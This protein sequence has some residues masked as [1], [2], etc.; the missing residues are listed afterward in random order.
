MHTIS[1]NDINGHKGPLNVGAVPEGYDAFLVAQLLQKHADQTVVFVARD[2][3]RLQ[4]FAEMVRFF[5]PKTEMLTFLPWDCLPYDRVS[6]S[7]HVTATRLQTLSRLLEVSKTSRCIVT[8]STAWG[9]YIVPPAFIQ[10]SSLVLQVGD[11]KPL[12]HVVNY[13]VRNGYQRVETV[14]DVGE[15]AVRGGIVDL[16][17]AGQHPL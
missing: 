10:N 5:A 1:L 9:Q 12:E 13:C 15:Y 7:K 2:D 16:F 11:T 6:P 4:V 3:M 17:P 8:S 14:R